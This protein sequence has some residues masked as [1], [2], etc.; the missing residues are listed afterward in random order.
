MVA[1]LNEQPHITFTEVK[2]DAFFDY[3]ELLDRFYKSF[4]A[5]TVQS[6]HC[7]WVESAAPTKVFTRESYLE[8]TREIEF[9]N[10]RFCQQQHRLQELQQFTLKNVPPPGLREIKQ[11][12]LFTKW[13]K[14]VLAE[15]QDEIC[16][17][18]PDEV[19][20]S[21]QKTRSDNNKERSKR[22]ATKRKR[23]S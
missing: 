14:F 22:N 10:S 18:P 12:E 1:T 17:K 2:A 20:A 16:P 15:F 5:G 9:M 8:A 4:P 3:G 7:F 6:N 23:K 19:I 13:R 11:V 21:V